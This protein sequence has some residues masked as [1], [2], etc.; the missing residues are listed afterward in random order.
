[1]EDMSN[2]K[3]KV[4]LWTHKSDCKCV[5]CLAKRASKKV[6]ETIQNTKDAAAGAA[7]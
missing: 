1:M 5:G 7:H 2:M 3:N 4:M 6:V